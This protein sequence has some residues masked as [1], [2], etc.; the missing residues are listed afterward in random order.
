MDT[1]KIMTESQNSK[2]MHQAVRIQVNVAK[3]GIQ[4]SKTVCSPPKAP[5]AQWPHHSQTA[6]IPGAVPYCKKG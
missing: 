6:G 5:P 2:A 3:T 1:A 4:N